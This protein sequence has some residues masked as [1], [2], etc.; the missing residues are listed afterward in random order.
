MAVLDVDKVSILLKGAGSMIPICSF[1][2]S[3]LPHYSECESKFHCDRKVAANVVYK[4][5]LGLVD[6]VLV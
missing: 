3:L 2:I 6:H 4:Y 5:K 1:P